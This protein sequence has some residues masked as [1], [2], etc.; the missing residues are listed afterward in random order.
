M[1]CV[2]TKSWSQPNINTRI[3]LIAEITGNPQ[4]KVIIIKQTET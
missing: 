3:G 4:M 2:L 1:Y